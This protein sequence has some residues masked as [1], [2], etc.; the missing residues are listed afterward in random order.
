MQKEKN[1]IDPVLKNVLFQSGAIVMEEFQ[2]ALVG[3]SVGTNPRAIYDVE[4]MIGLLKVREKW[5]EEECWEW[6]EYNTFSSF[7]SDMNK[8]APIFLYPF[9]N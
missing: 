5:S 6:L 4:K 2:S 8:N 1:L 7:P 3:H 9:K